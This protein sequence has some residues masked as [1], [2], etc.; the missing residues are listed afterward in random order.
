MNSAP[1]RP[2]PNEEWREH[3]AHPA[4]APP[5]AYPPV[6]NQNRAPSPAPNPTRPSGSN[7][8]R[9]QERLSAP[10][11][12]KR[13]E[14]NSW[15]GKARLREEFQKNDI[16]DSSDS[17]TLDR[18]YDSDPIHADGYGVGTGRRAVESS[19]EKEAMKER[20]DKKEK[21]A[22]KGLSPSGAWRDS[23]L[24]SV[25]DL[26]QTYLSAPPRENCP[27]Y[28]DSS[29][30]TPTPLYGSSR[31]AHLLTPTP[32]PDSAIKRAPSPS[33][34]QNPQQQP[35]PSTRP[36]GNQNAVDS[37]HASLAKAR[38]RPSVESE[39]DRE[40]NDEQNGRD[41]HGLYVAGEEKKKKKKGF[42]KNVFSRKKTLEA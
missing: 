6:A 13:P 36:L 18:G 30:L 27:P 9:E 4:A 11:R 21:E 33:P 15:S 24:L 12:E 37:G 23:S 16:S 20:E 41:L 28:V 17:D 10:A 25:E 7:A 26:G 32:V 19:K 39:P 14:R 3:Q 22:S 34:S 8:P 1:G 40:A 35:S 38:S 31:K 42:I 29:Q 2:Q 5:A